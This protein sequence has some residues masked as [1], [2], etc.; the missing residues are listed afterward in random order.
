MCHIPHAR[1]E[2]QRTGWCGSGD[3]SGA[4]EL[5]EAVEPGLL[6][7]RRGTVLQQLLRHEKRSCWAGR[8]AAQRGGST[9]PRQVQGGGFLFVEVVLD[10][11]VVVV[12]WM[13][14]AGLGVDAALRSSDPARA[15][16]RAASRRSGVDACHP[17]SETFSARAG[18]GRS[19]L[20]TRLSPLPGAPNVEELSQEQWASRGVRYRQG[21]EHGIKQ[22]STCHGDGA[23][24]ARSGTALQRRTHGITQVQGPLGEVKPL[25][26]A[27]GVL[28]CLERS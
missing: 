18:H 20:K 26:P 14:N 3:A 1:R 28:H 11:A 25:R 27:F 5:G 10:V 8:R 21:A 4:D 23:R 9:V 13:L 12:L 6:S 24:R 19:R 7:L 16:A 2:D 15:A 22:P 17:A